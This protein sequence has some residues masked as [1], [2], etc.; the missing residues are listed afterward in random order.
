MVSPELIIR[1]SGHHVTND[2]LV[3][4]IHYGEGTVPPRD[5]HS[6]GLLATDW[7]NHDISQG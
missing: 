7:G 1:R 3:A 4:T 2:R 6:S 5:G